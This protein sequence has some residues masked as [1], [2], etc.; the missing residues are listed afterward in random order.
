MRKDRE[1]FIKFLVQRLAKLLQQVKQADWNNPRVIL[2]GICA[3]IFPFVAWYYVS[4]GLLLGLVMAIGTLW[5]LEKS[6]KFIQA[7]VVD[8][9]LMSDLVLGLVTVLLV[10]GF[11]G[12]GLVLVLGVSFSTVILSW[13]LPVFAKKFEEENAR[14]ATA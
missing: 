6:P 9:P 13:A 5:L 14:E 8:Y 12:G 2:L 4:T 11:A 10:G 7:M 1:S 3:V